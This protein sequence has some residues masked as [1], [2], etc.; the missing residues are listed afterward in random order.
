M[1]KTNKFTSEYSKWISMYGFFGATAIMFLVLVLLILIVFFVAFAL[2]F[3]WNN[4]V[5]PAMN[6]NTIT[7]KQSLSL[8]LVFS[9]LSMFF[10]HETK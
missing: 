3:G 6:M 5:V 10:K 1:S 7:F 9:V 2:M 4:G 8:L